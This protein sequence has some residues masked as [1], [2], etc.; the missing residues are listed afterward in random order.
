MTLRSRRKDIIPLKLK[1][2]LKNKDMLKIS[3]RKILT[4]KKKYL[5]PDFILKTNII[6]LS[7]YT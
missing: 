6:Y 2:S 3:I 5:S 1:F 7:D 4:S